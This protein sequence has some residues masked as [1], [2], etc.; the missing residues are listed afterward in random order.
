MQSTLLLPAL[1]RVLL[2]YTSNENNSNLKKKTPSPKSNSNSHLL[3]YNHVRAL[4][5]VLYQIIILKTTL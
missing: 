1:S 3:I 2:C 4:L 5:Q